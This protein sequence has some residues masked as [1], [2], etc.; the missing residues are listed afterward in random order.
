MKKII[1]LFALSI[2]FCFFSCDSSDDSQEEQTEETTEDGT[3]DEPV[4]VIDEPIDEPIIQEPPVE[5]A[6]CN[7]LSSLVTDF[8]GSTPTTVT[9][10]KCEEY[11]AAINAFIESGCPGS[12]TSALTEALEELGDCM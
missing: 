7:A 11:K 10:E 4:I 3:T 1:L 6:D 8:A 12:G 9:G 2:N 5:V